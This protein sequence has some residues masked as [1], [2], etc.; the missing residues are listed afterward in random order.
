M[1]FAAPVALA[2]LLDGAVAQHAA[3]PWWWH[4]RSPSHLTASVMTGFSLPVAMV[5]AVG[6]ATAVALGSRAKTTQQVAQTGLLVG[7][8]QVL[9]VFFLAV[10]LKWPARIMWIG[11]GSA[12][13]SGFV[14]GMISI[15]L[16]PYLEN[17]FSRMS[18][19]RLL[20]LAAANHPLLQKMSIEAPGTY[21]HS[22]I[23][24]AL[25]EDAGNAIGANGLLCR[26]GAYFHDIGKMVKAE[27]FIENQGTFGNPHD[28][29]SPSLSRLVITSHVKEGMA[30]ARAN[31]LDAQVADFI[32]QHHGTSKIEYFYRKALKLE[33]SEDA[34]AQEDITEEA[35]R[36]PGPK[37]QSKE[38]GIVML[39]DSVEAA[40]RTL[41]EPTHQRYKDLVTQIIER[42]LADGQLDE[43]P[44]TLRDLR[45]IS[46]RFTTTLLSINH[47]R[48]PYPEQPGDEKASLL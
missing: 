23:M 8:V 47:N 38:T 14:A 7:V 31:K 48:I 28:Q 17:F 15:M 24:A 36:Y 42:K 18:N 35:Y 12:L 11:L 39:A 20:E 27:Y 46:E 29:V 5:S 13:A 33:E 25:A 22:M 26:V 30:L 10:L 19:V 1:P 4:F 40:S 44:L 32:P 34:A 45:A 16:L 43:T 37:P 3:W 41:E 2:P 21:H 9:V 6:G